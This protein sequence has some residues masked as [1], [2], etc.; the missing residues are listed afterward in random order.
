MKS[1]KE[2][3]GEKMCDMRGMLSFTILWLLSRRPMY[4]QELATE[5]GNRRGDKPN[6]GTIYPALKELAA[7]RLIVASRQG[8]NSVYELTEEG[9]AILERSMEYFERAYGDIFNELRQVTPASQ[10]A[11]ATRPR[12]GRPARE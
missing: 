12:D 5:I 4:G 7:R 6:P 2:E 9:K 11:R 1:V 3:G 8:R 10:K